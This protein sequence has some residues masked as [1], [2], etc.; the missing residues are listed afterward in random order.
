MENKTKRKRQK[1][2]KIDGKLKKNER[3]YEREKRKEN[4]NGMKLH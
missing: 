1:K 2:K 4:V 3:S